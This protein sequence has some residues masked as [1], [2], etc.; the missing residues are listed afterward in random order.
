[1]HYEASAEV[2]DSIAERHVAL[3]FESNT[4]VSDI[5][6]PANGPEHYY[7]KP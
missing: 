6:R 7:E 2:Q 1:M 4:A 3:P 5:V